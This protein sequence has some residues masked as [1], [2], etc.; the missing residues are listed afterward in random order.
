MR[1][2]CW[3]RGRGPDLAV[4]VERGGIVVRLDMDVGVGKTKESEVAGIWA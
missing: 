3:A 2:D 1:A 4:V